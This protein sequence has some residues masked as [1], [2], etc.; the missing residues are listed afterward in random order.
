MLNAFVGHSFDPSD[1]S[2]IQTFLDYFESL[3]GALPFHWDHAERASVS[4][5][6]AKV[7]QLM[8]DKNLFIGICT[9]RWQRIR[10]G[11]LKS[12]LSIRGSK[13]GAPKNEFQFAT[14]DWLHQEI[15]FAMGRGMNVLLLVEEGLDM[16]R[17]LYGDLE[18]IPFSRTNPQQSFARIVQ[19][20]GSLSPATKSFVAEAAEPPQ[21]DAVKDGVTTGMVETEPKPKSSYLI[22]YLSALDDKD[23]QHANEIYRHRLADLERDNPA[24]AAHW[25]ADCLYYRHHVLE[26]PTLAKMKSL[27]SEYAKSWYVRRRY[28]QLLAFYREPDSAVENLLAAADM[29]PDIRQRGECYTL[30]AEILSKAGEGEKAR[31]LIDSE[32]RPLAGDGCERLFHKAHFAVA[33]REKNFLVMAIHGE[34]ALHYSPD[35]DDIR[36]RLGWGYLQ[37]DQNALALHHYKVLADGRSYEGDW[38][39]LGVAYQGLELPS[40]AVSAYKKSEELGGTIAVGNMAYKLL[41]EGFTDEAEAMC[42]TALKLENVESRVADAMTAVS[43]RKQD[44]EASEQAAL[45]RINQLRKFYVDFALALLKPTVPLAAQYKGP[46][47]IYAVSVTGETIR[48]HARYELDEMPYTGLLGLGLS[49]PPGALSQPPAKR[50]HDETFIGTRAGQSVRFTR[51]VETSGRGGFSYG[52]SEKPGLMVLDPDLRLRVVEL[53]DEPSFYDLTPVQTASS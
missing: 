49:S 31:A 51:T 21:S 28:G 48:L 43:K 52:K 40:K 16:S 41:A 47:A 53:G 3:T 19:M 1:R 33:E 7:K 22:D 37:D 34:A 10:P 12:T 15:G 30:A 9:Q 18:H 2:L 20:L 17:G 25:K 29:A 39:N 26:Q 42:K 46:V 14:S 5:V 4:E 36:F 6:S 11:N 35:D 50:I 45:G 32:L 38:N 8:D 27:V 13:V 44:D 24:E 23:E